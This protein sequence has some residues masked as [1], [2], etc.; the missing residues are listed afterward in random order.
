MYWVSNHLLN[1][2]NMKQL[3]LVTLCSFIVLSIGC[4]NKGSDFD[5]SGVFEAEEYIIS[6]EVPGLLTNFDLN[7]GLDIP[8]NSV[9][10]HIDCEPF[11]LK[12]AQVEASLESLQLKQNEAAPQTDILKEQLVSQQAQI[13]VLNT[14]L[15]VQLKEKRRLQ[16]LVERKAAPSKQLDDVDG[17][18]QVLEKQIQAAEKQQNIIQQQIKSTQ[19]QVA[20]QNRSILS[21]RKP[22]ES[23]IAVIE[24]QIDRC[25]IINPIGG[26]VLN[27]Y[28]NNYEMV[29]TGKALYQIADLEFMILR[30]YISG[31]QLTEIQLDQK[32]LVLVDDNQDS[33]RQL[34]GRVIWIADQAEFTPKT[35]QTKEERTQL[36]YAI[37]VKVK[38][39]G[40]LKIGMY[41]EIKFTEDD[42]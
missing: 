27:T 8:A 3:Q 1:L 5:A 21:E 34:E 22:L 10:G 25:Q 38:N 31:D 15:E 4:N 33:Y 37:K 16:N 23:Q 29:T 39:D 24:D 28:V 2:I 18:I 19:R 9:V 35:I 7:E 20:I 26:T 30:A 12:K 40:R 32:V 42:E 17:Q 41:G 13:E 14:R 36:V 6:A 11:L